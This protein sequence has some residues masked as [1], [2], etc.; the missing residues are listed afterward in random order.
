LNR[1]Q[2]EQ[3]RFVLGA[4]GH[5]AGVINPPKK[6]KRHY[7]TN[8]ASAATAEEWLDKAAQHPG[9]WWPEWAAFLEKH[10]GARVAPP[11]KY[12]N[13]NYKPIEPAP[14]RYVKVKIQ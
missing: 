3:N 1:K 6:K 12:G 8:D 9:S 7:W 5:I 11:G 13:V 2:P 14:G 4:S 10:A